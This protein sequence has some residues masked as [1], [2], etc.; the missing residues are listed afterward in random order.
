MTLEAGCLIVEVSIC[1]LDNGCMKY[2]CEART[3][4][5]LSPFAICGGESGL[6]RSLDGVGG[7]V[8]LVMVDPLL[9]SSRRFAPTRRRGIIGVVRGYVCLKGRM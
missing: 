6:L 7:A 8:M 4:R 9:C 5:S 2:Q 1:D 3:S